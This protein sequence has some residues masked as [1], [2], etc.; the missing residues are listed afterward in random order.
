MNWSKETTPPLA[1]KTEE[2]VRGNV[3]KVGKGRGRDFG[4]V[5]PDQSPM[6]KPGSKQGSIR[7][8]YGA[9]LGAKL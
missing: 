4:D 8:T 9:V 7:S 3:F 5:L 1:A 2:K 6:W